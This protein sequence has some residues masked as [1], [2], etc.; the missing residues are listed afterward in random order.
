MPEEKKTNPSAREVAQAYAN[1]KTKADKDRLLAY[2]KERAK[3]GRKRWVTVAKDMANNDMVRIN[4]RASGYEG[5][6]MDAFKALRVKE[7]SV[8]KKAKPSA[9]SAD[10]LNALL[11]NANEETRVAVMALLKVAKR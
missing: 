7:A 10:P 1:A 4:A 3:S 11:A 9:P 5:K 2:A 8:A 6:A